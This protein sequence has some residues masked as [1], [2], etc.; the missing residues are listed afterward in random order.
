MTIIDFSVNERPSQVG[1]D[2]NSVKQTFNVT[3]SRPFEGS[4]LNDIDLETDTEYNLTSA[5]GC[6]KT[7]SIA[8]AN[9]QYSTYNPDALSETTTTTTTTKDANDN[10]V[11]VTNYES[12]GCFG[13]W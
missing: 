10:D 4:D 11:D 9:G 2:K 6:Y 8:D 12:T 5:Y 3:Y 1:A 13:V 7:S